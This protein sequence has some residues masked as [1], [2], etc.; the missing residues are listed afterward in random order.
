MC[1]GAASGVCRTMGTVG[2]DESWTWEVWRWVDALNGRGGLVVRYSATASSCAGGRL[3]GAD[4]DGICMTLWEV[5][6]GSMVLREAEGRV[7]T[8]ISG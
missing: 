7:M 6:G 3:C 8:D 2:A 5:V 1:G 4:G